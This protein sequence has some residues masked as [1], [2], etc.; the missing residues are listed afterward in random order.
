[1]NDL[2]QVFLFS[3]MPICE[4]SGSIPMGIALFKLPLWQVFIVSLL[5]NS[6]IPFFVLN[7][8]EIIVNFLSDHSQFFKKIIT[9]FLERT[10]MKNVKSFE[11]YRDLALFIIVVLPFPFAGTWTASVCAYLFQVP[12]KRTIFLII[13]GNTIAAILIVLA[14]LGVINIAI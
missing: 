3:M 4:L 2:F 5:G 9:W 1:M 7:F 8:M 6:L 11:T 10:R 12:F 13:T 14:T